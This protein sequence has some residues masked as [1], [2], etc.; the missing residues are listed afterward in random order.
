MDGM[1]IF[2]LIF[3]DDYSGICQIVHRQAL[4]AAGT[5]TGSHQKCSVK[6]GIFKILT[7]FTG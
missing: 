6:I 4:F 5:I 3:F 7:N 2:E 1:E